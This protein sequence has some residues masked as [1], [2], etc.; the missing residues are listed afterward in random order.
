M[1]RVQELVS[2]RLIT[3]IA[4]PYKLILV[5][6]NGGDKKHKFYECKTDESH[7]DQE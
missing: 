5:D 2:D 7:Y 3:E 6:R 1:A 4:R